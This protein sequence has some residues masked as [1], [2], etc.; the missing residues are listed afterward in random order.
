MASSGELDGL[1]GVKHVVLVL[2]GK[3]GVG[4]STVS[5]ELAIALKHA[6]KK[7]GILDID[8]CGPSIPK[9]FGVEESAIHQCDE[10]WVPVYVTKDQGLAL[11][12]I[13]FLLGNPKDPVV[14]RGPKKTAMIKQFL[15]DVVWGDLDFLII[16][17]PPGTSDEHIS[18]VENLRA[19]NP[20]GAVVVTTPQG[21]ATLDVR[22]EL[23]FCKR[24]RLKV[25]GVVENMSG[26]AC[27]CCKEITY[28]F[29]TGGGEQMA[30]DFNVPFLG[31][32]PID[33]SVSALQEKGHNYAEELPKANIFPTIQE[34]A[35]PILALA[36]DD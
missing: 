24:A 36:V 32:L 25:L 13:G 35:A 18:V 33:P 28:I 2:S 15:S 10:G 1:K 11:M 23:N 30:K 19:Y 6:G 17:T 31:R 14:W 26:Y 12:S 3:G 21:V 8:L 20:D 4:K 34:I 7:V 5:T 29:S 16:D 27:Q 9:M 22:K